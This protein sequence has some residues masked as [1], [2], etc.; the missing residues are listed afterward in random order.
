M[1]R[2]VMDPSCAGGMP[3]S[4]GVQE[5][6]RLGPRALRHVPTEMK[7]PRDTFLKVASL[8]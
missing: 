6:G 8:V 4:L 1:F 3:G 2:S 5:A 7:S